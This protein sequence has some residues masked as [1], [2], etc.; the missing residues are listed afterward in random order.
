MLQASPG[1]AEVELFQLPVLYLLVQ[2]PQGFGVFRRHY[3]AAGVPVDAVHQSRSKGVLLLGPVLALI[4]QVM[5]H[6]GDQGIEVVVLVRVD[7]ESGLF[8][9]QQ[10][11]FILIHNVQF[12]GGF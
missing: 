11:V 2:H 3:N 7:D 10:D 6:P 9:Q 4:I 12:G 5:L 8:I 1:Q